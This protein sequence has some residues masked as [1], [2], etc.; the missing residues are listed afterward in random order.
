MNLE[1]RIDI[2]KQIFAK[3][4]DS[5]LAAGFELRLYDGEAFCTTHCTDRQI[6]I[7]ASMSTDDDLLCVYNHIYDTSHKRERHGW[8]Q[9]IYGNDGYD[10]IHDYTTNIEDQI[11]PAMDLAD[12]LEATH[13]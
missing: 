4:V 5:L 1:T 8:V 9:F 7:D 11:R 6:I 12:E 3:V 10:V 2:E 13:G